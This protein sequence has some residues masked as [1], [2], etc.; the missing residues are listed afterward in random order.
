MARKSTVFSVPLP[1]TDDDIPVEVTVLDGPDRGRHCQ[2]EGPVVF[3]GSSPEVD[4]VLV[5]RKVSGQHLSIERRDGRFVLR[6]LDSKNGTVFQGSLIGELNVPL[7]AV[8]T[9][10][11]TRL[12][13]RPLEQ[14][15]DLEPS[16]S[17]RFGDMVGE[18]IAMRRVFALLEL[19][20]ES[21]VTVLVTGETGTGKEM[22]ARGLHDLG[23]RRKHPLVAVDC[24]AMPQ[25]LLESE[26]FGHVKGA[27][28]G[29]D[30]SRKGAF[31]RA[32]GGTLFLDEMA[33]VPE[34]VQARLLRAIESRAIRPLGA[35]REVQVDIRIV[36]A[37]TDDLAR[38]V[39]A[40]RFRS[41]LYY[42]LSVLQVEL[43][44]LRERRADLALLVGD[45]LRRRALDLGS[46]EGPNLE[47][48]RSHEW[49][50]NV[51]ELRNVIDRAVTLSPRAE[52]WN[53]L[54]LWLRATP[55][56]ESGIEVRTDLDYA[57]AKEAV[58]G[59]F[60][61]TYLED[62]LTRCD[63]NISAAAREA[64]VDRKHFRSLLKKHGLV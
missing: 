64:N 63:G 55:A 1:A 43:P 29:A 15:L 34:A 6:D 23:E 9:V 11:E 51:R 30:R 60:E 36:A 12:Q 28:T 45:L 42:R 2:L 26:L 37:S 8:I 3:I 41:D 33:R 58:L 52:S 25:G 27:F 21:D 7:G 39:D 13:I 19:A 16:Q 32:S 4:L 47:K 50:G 48:L 44:P 18:S 14:D 62:V 61:R 5:D 59:R 53:D 40:G 35:E 38:A 31:E 46:I 17:R 57:S 10:G 20:A 49:P 24:G 56:S 54:K 22:V